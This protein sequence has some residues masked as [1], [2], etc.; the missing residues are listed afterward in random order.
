MVMAML[1]KPS[2]RLSPRRPWALPLALTIASGCA[3]DETGVDPPED[4]LYY[5]LSVATHPDGRYLYVANA[6]FDR[7]FNAGT[8]TVF[9]TWTR[10]VVPAATVHIGL[11]AGE[12][13]VG[14]PDNPE[15][16]PS[17]CP[18]VGYV[19]TREDSRLTF[20][21]VAGAAEAAFEAGP[22]HLRCGQGTGR[23]CGRSAVIGTFGTEAA[24]SGSPFGV[25]LDGS[26][27]TLTHVERGVMSRWGW[28]PPEAS[29][30]PAA[31]LPRSRTDFRC[32]LTLPAGASSVARHPVLGWHYVTDR[33]GSRIFAI[34]ERGRSERAEASVDLASCELRASAVISVD[35]NPQRGATRGIAFSADG[36]LMYVAVSTDRALRIYDTSLDPDGIPRNR[37]VATIPLGFQPNVVRVA[38]LRPDEVRAPDGLDRGPAGAVV[39]AQGGG[40]VYVSVFGDDRV[41]VIDPSTLAVVAR[42]RVGRGPQDIAFLPDPD[43]RLRGY[44]SNFEE[45]SLSI[46]DLDPASPDRFSRLATVR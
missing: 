35:P 31:T 20:F 8:V 18:T 40:L 15:C 14:R 44:V 2:R 1:M 3:V 17:G 39:E 10:R 36:T 22:E 4:S 23:I 6:V 45:H 32:G 41:A 27:V 11:F 28:R 30:E 26:G 21:E 5:P 9:D 24:F 42:I 7:S 43:G 19:V 37:L 38:G 34:S 12:L 46:L 13:V 33:I 25:S 16:G 29:A